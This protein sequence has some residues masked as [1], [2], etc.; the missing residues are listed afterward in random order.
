MLRFCHR[1]PRSEQS[2][3]ARGRDHSTKDGRLTV[4]RV[5]DISDA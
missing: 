5:F 3:S 4:Y 2:D 1:A